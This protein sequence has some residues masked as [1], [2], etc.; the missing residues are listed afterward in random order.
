MS[1]VYLWT[2]PGVGVSL[3]PR[4]ACPACWPADLGRAGLSGQRGVLV[5]FDGRAPGRCIGGNGL[6]SK[7]FTT[8]IKIRFATR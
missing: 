4:P 6:Q 1:R 5:A 2:L 7:S 3:L 8:C